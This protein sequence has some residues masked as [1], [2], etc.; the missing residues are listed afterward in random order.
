MNRGD[1]AL[2]GMAETSDQGQDVQTELMVRKGQEGFRLGVEGAVVA[3]AIGVRATANAQRQA[4]DGIA[5]GNRAA[6][7][8]RCPEE[9]AAF[10]ARR[11]NMSKRLGLGRPQSMMST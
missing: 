10:S 9:V 11:G 7:G 5:G 8:V 2:L 6:V 1:T 4:L 3:G